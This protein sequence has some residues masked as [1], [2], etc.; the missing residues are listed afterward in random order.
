[1]CIIVAKP[2][3]ID[4]PSRSTLMNC[5]NHNHDGAGFMYADGKEVTVMKGFFTFEELLYGDGN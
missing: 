2:A 5:F 1:M 3:G 4:L